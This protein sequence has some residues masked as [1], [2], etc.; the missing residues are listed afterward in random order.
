MTHVLRGE[1]N[2][3]LGSVGFEAG[4]GLPRKKGISYREEYKGRG[5]PEDSGGG[6]HAE[7]TQEGAHKASTDFSD[8]ETLSVQICLRKFSINSL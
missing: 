4:S 7:G 2:G 8:L 1:S 6:E 5:R 3:D